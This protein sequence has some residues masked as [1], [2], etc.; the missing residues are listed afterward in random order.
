VRR[1]LWLTCAFI[2]AVVGIPLAWLAECLSKLSIRCGAAVGRCLCK[3][4]FEGRTS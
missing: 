1:T 4:A 3:A 2:L